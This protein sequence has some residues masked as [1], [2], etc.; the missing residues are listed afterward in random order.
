MKNDPEDLP[1]AGCLF[2]IGLPILSIAIGIE[3]G[4]TFG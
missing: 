2:L 4:A 3:F 1:V